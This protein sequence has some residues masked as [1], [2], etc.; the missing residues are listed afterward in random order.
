M[1]RLRRHLPL[2]A[3]RDQKL[4]QARPEQPFRRD[5][6]AGELRVKRRKLR[7]AA[8]HHPTDLAQRM[9]SGDALFQINK[10]NSAPLAASFP[11]IF[12]F[13][14]AGQSVVMFQKPSQAPTVSAPC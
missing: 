2:R 12:T 3:G 10:L 9:P 13:A 7:N 6:R 5:R 14:I 4:D 1:L 11:H 8:G